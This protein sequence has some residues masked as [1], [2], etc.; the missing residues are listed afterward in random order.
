MDTRRLNRISEFQ[1]RLEK[2]GK[3][4]VPGIIFASKGLLEGMDDK[5]L[6]Q[7][8]NVACLPGIV[9]AS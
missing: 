2:T 5:V 1:W 3:M 9:S 4:R 7:V 8:S 6:E